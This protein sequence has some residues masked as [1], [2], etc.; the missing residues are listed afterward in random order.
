VRENELDAYVDDSTFRD[1]NFYVDRFWYESKRRG[2]THVDL[3]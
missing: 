1:F 3:T 2:K